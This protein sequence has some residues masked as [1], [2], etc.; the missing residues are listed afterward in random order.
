MV[1]IYWDVYGTVPFQMQKSNPYLLIPGKYLNPTKKTLAYEQQTPKVDPPKP[2]V[3]AMKLVKHVRT[4]QPADRYQYMG[5]GSLNK[6]L[7]LLYT[8]SGYNKAFTGQTLGNAGGQIFKYDSNGRYYLTHGNPGASASI[9]LGSNIPYTLETTYFYEVMETQLQ[10]GHFIGNCA[11]N[12]GVNTGV[13]LLRGAQLSA[14]MC[15]T[16]AVVTTATSPNP[17]IYNKWRRLAVRIRFNGINYTLSLFEEGVLVAENTGAYT[18]PNTGASIIICGTSADF[19]SGTSYANILTIATWGRA[20]SD[21]E[22]KSLSDNPWQIFQPESKT[23]WVD[24]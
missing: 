24:A 12:Y 21:A 5:I 2:K 14:V 9:S 10:T 7:Q 11:P 15:T 22:I 6:G 3:K 8:G 16:G 13:S 1:A 4:K 17:S 20:L 23:V 18:K 19:Y